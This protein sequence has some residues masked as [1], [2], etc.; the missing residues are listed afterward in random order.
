MAVTIYPYKYSDLFAS[1]NGRLHGKMGL[2]TNPR[3]LLNDVVNEVSG[4]YLRS[5]KTK[6]PLA[7]NLFNDIYQYAAPSNIDGGKI[8][9][10]QPQ[11]MIR[12]RNNIWDLVTEE[13]F[14]T[15]KQTDTNLIAFADHSFVKTLLVSSRNGGLRE[16]SIA[17][18][19]GLTG[20]SPSGASWAAFGNATNL[21][22]DTYNYIKGSGSLSFDLTSGGTTAGI[23][24]TTANT[25]DVT[26][27]YSAGSVFTWAYITT[28][29]DVTNT[30]VRL[31]NDASN[32][33][34]MTATTPND[35]TVFVA[36][37]N[38]IRFDFNTKT[39]VGTPVITTFKYIALFHT[40]SASNL[41]TTGYRFN[42]LNAKQGNI[43]NLIYYGNTPW[44]SSLG[45]YKEVSFLD[46]DY[47]C[48]D[49][50]EYGLM[51]E[52]GVEVCG[53][54]AREEQDASLAAARYGTREKPGMAQD[55]KRNY[56][57][58]AL[59]LTSTVYYMGNG[60]GYRDNSNIFLR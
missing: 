26:Q 38:L 49:Q 46:T 4:L 20:D 2:V 31:G 54:A 5:A 39:I 19:Q 17:G 55:Y 41:T 1:V 57:T 10:L 7:P 58:E 59:V 22:T 60:G 11:S 50:D 27:Y 13:E 43:S 56:P 8:I 34:E 29:S 53:M 14:D 16:A 47:L 12:D 44:E 33:C 36:G 15:R 37:W 48:C 51:V 18:I 6:A 42:W 9:G 21:A 3:N 40:L 32:Y 28:A 30:K 24:L 25:F 35:G 45:V 23:V 52:K